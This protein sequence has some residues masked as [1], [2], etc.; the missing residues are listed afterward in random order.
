MLDLRNPGG[1]IIGGLFGGFFGIATGSMIK[2]PVVYDEKDMD[3]RQII[4]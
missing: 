3:S 1:G 4:K 2:I